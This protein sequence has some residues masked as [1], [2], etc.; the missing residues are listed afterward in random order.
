MVK[1]FVSS[2]IVRKLRDL[3]KWSQKE[4]ARR[5]G[6]TLRTISKIEND[7][8]EKRQ[9]QWKV[10]VGL[11][12]AFDVREE[13]L[14]GNEPLNETHSKIKSSIEISSQQ[15]LD[16][17]LVC[18]SYNIKRTHLMASMSALFVLFAEKALI[19]MRQDFSRDK[20]LVETGSLDVVMKKYFLEDPSQLD[21]LMKYRKSDIEENNINSSNTMRY[22]IELHSIPEEPIDANSKLRSL[23]RWS[24]WYD[25]L[26][27]EMDAT[28]QIRYGIGNGLVD[29]ISVCNAALAKIT[30]DSRKAAEAL[31][32]GYVTI[33]EIPGELWQPQNAG[34]RVEWLEDAYEH[35]DSKFWEELLKGAERTS[36]M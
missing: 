23:F 27:D 6:T 29:K 18:R 3:N 36:G 11:R 1:D 21:K 7:L 32:N 25:C 30:C 2:K 14:R 33:S 9:V 13:V 28:D 34:K 12:D 26:A 31:E 8:K 35:G 17:D 20:Y 15:N 10:F 5:S 16:I 24:P 19:K 22:L 4:L